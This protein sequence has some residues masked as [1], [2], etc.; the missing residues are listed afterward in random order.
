MEITCFLCGRDYSLPEDELKHIADHI[1]DAEDYNSF[2]I[3]HS[4]DKPEEMY[5]AP[6]EGRGACAA[7]MELNPTLE[8]FRFSFWNKAVK[9]PI[10][11]KEKLSFEQEMVK[12]FI[13][14]AP[15]V[16]RYGSF[17]F[18]LQWG[19]NELYVNWDEYH[20]DYYGV[21]INFINKTVCIMC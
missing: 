2:V 4:D 1:K 19:D 18:P 20:D 7:M 12:S 9:T 11:E 8:G 6:S 3:R 5:I 15:D 14:Q 16:R 10:P 17:D 21:R 13:E